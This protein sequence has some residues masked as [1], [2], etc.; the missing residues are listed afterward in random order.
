LKQFQLLFMPIFLAIFNS[1][2]ASG[3]WLSPWKTSLI[4][5]LFNKGNPADYSNYRPILL[6]PSPSKILERILDSRLAEWLQKYH[7]LKKEEV[8]RRLQY[9][10]Q[11][12]SP[13]D[14]CGKIYK[15]LHSL[16]MCL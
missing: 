3:E 8:L 14:T 11:S 10:R 16:I 4:L 13:S 6:V 15:A 5:P 2:P 1:V 9:Y 12:P 7:I